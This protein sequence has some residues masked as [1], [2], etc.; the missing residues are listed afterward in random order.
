MIMKSQTSPM[1]FS[2]L[3]FHPHTNYP[4]TGIGAKHFFANGYGVSV[5]RFTSPYG[6]G[7]SYGAEQGLYERAV[8]KGVE[9]NWE[10]CY[11]TVI[12][13]DVL[14]YLTE[15]EVEVLL[16]EIENLTV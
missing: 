15:E 10:I 14:G 13:D 12:A 4:D 5:V 6:F 2:D 3:N 1:N 9:D 7:G 11:D 16:Y 8:L